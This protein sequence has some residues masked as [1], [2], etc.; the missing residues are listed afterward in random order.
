MRMANEID[1]IYLEDMR[2]AV[3]HFVSIREKGERVWMVGGL[4][5]C[6]L[7]KIVPALPRTVEEISELASDILQEERTDLVSHLHP[8]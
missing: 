4:Q 2:E 3:P 7:L 1:S 6:R 5:T 8:H